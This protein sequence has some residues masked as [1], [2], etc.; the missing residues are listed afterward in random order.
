[1]RKLITFD[2]ASKR[3]LRDKANFDILEGFLSELLGQGLR[4]QKILEAESNKNS[5]Q[6]KSNIVDLLVEDQSGELIIIEVQHERELDYLQRMLFGA[7]KLVTEYLAE[8]KPY[9]QIKKVISVNIVYFNLGKGDDYVYHGKTEFVGRRTGKPLLLSAQQRKLYTDSTDENSSAALLYPEY[10]LLKV[11]QFDDT[12]RD[13]LDEWI[14][15]LKNEEIRNDFAAQGLEKAKETLDVLKLPDEDRRAYQ[16][17]LEDLHYQAS[18]V[19]SNY[20]LGQ[21]EGKEEGRKEERV[22]IA[23]RLLKRGA[24][25]TTIAD[26]TQLTVAE[27][28]QLTAE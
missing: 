17:Y 7:S 12:I 9:S 4:I 13:P 2:W 3:L 5:V 26:A 23:Q 19:E 28:E 25:H 21:I 1:M 27:I 6:D 16:K 22:A 8:G 11:E 14:Y 15:F 20:T 18:L 10:F 24:D